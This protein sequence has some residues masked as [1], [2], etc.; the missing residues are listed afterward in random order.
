MTAPQDASSYGFELVHPGWQG[1]WHPVPQ[2]LLAVSLSGTGAMEG[3][4]AQ[5]SGDE[6]ARMAARSPSR[7]RMHHAESQDAFGLVRSH[8]RRRMAC[9]TDT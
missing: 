7:G 1:D 9:R 3:S 5:S 8:V 4:S 6:P 2:R